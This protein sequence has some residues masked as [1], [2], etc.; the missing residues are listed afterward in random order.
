MQFLRKTCQPL[1]HHQITENVLKW[2]K[3]NK[4]ELPW[5]DTR[6]PYKIWLSEIILQQTRVNQGLPYYHNFLEK[7]PNINALAKAEEQDVLRIWQGLGYYSRARNLHKCAQIVHEKYSGD[8]PESY[9]EIIKLPGIGKY[10]AAAIASFA[11][12]EVQPAIDGN[13][14]R[15]LS[16]LFGITEDIA[17]AKSR[18]AFEQ[19]AFDLIP[20]NEP[21]TYNQAMMEFGAVQCKPKNPLCETCPLTMDCYARKEGKQDQLPVKNNKIKIRNRY[22]YY[23]VF[24]SGEKIWLKKRS[25]GD[26]WEGLYD[27]F[28]EEKS[29][30]NLSMIELLPEEYAASIRLIG[31]PTRVYKHVLSHQRIFAQFVQVE[32][33]DEKLNILPKIGDFYTKEEVGEL[34]KPVLISSYLNEHNF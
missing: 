28:L 18:K 23:F 25:A 2:Y 8:F 21:D 17:Q 7:F 3:N 6:D 30:G 19:V 12:R 10:T 9:E 16:R 13:V 1:N 26:V 5:R 32:I 27:F 31:T 29:E 15:V 22:F 20:E 24:T 4:R 33:P 14:F 11:F 34:P